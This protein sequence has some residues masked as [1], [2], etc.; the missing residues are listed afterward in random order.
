MYINPSEIFPLPLQINM[1]DIRI[2]MSMR[3]VEF[4]ICKIS[5]HLIFQKNL[6]V[7]DWA[8]HLIYHVV[9]LDCL[10]ASDEQIGFST[11]P[12]FQLLRYYIFYIFI[13]FCQKYKEA[14]I[15]RSYVSQTVCS[16][17]AALRLPQ[18][19]KKYHFDE[20]RMNS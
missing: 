5:I 2:S 16:P 18:V 14:P 15:A 20:S 1:S 13:H 10:K 6:I 19:I 4:N 11:T 3:I 17:V 8:P 7:V 9:S 12:P